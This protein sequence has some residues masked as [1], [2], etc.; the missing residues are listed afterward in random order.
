MILDLTHLIDPN[1]VTTIASAIFGG[2]GVEIL[3]RLVTRR[4]ETFHEAIKLREELRKQMDSMRKEME[5]WKTEADEWR[6]KY[7]EQVEKNAHLQ[8]SLE[9]LQVEIETVKSKIPDTSKPE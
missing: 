9:T 4:S 2:A 6:G 7:W 3:K 1:T 5:E 8:A